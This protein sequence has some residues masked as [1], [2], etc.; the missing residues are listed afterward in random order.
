M[1]NNVPDKEKLVKISTDLC[2]GCGIC[3]TV[4][5]FQIITMNPDTHLPEVTSPIDKACNRCGQCEAFCPNSAIII[6]D[7][8][9]EKIRRTDYALLPKEKEI[10]ELV[11]NRRSIRHYMNK[12]V[13]KETIESILDIVRYAPTAMNLQEVRW[14]VISEQETK[15]EIISHTVN[16]MRKLISEERTGDFKAGELFSKFV[17]R[18]DRG[19]NIVTHNAPHLLVTHSPQEITTAFQDAVIATS[20]LDLIAPVFHLGTCWAGLIKRA[21]D[22][23]PDVLK[24]L[25][26]PQDNI[27]HT[28]M[29][30]GYPRLK[31]V[32]IPKRKPVSIT[33]K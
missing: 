29:M 4:C 15:D 22:N 31:P 6:S 30:L 10:R 5:L 11:Q 8:P 28:I 9:D 21:A 18:Y 2:N 27:P 32:N 25:G 17:E 16:W 14:H 23:S 26:L 20:Y 1:I 3:S 19:E 12:Q 24:S 33:W 7:S 13:P